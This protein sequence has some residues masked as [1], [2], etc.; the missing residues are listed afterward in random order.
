MAKVGISVLSRFQ[1]NTNTWPVSTPADTM[2]RSKLHAKHICLVSYSTSV[3]HMYLGDVEAA[4]DKLHKQYGPL[5]RVAPNEVISN[6]SSAIPLIYRTHNPLPKTPWYDTV[7][8]VPRT[9]CADTVRP[10]QVR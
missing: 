6:D 9:L 3:Y 8:Y 1:V 2:R 7:I 10:S 5:I 4:Q